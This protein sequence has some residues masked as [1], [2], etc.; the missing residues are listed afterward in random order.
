[1]EYTMDYQYGERLHALSR[2]IHTSQR[3][4]FQLHVNFNNIIK[5]HQVCLTSAQGPMREYVIKEELNSL[6]EIHEIRDEIEYINGQLQTADN[7]RRSLLPAP[8][9]FA[10]LHRAEMI[11]TNVINRDSH[12]TNWVVE[13]LHRWNGIRKFITLQLT[14]DI[15]SLS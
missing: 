7:Y 9:D 3:L 10:S 4:M 8:P 5:L 15:K 14:W 13:N 6:N 11:V 1:M 12:V 2:F